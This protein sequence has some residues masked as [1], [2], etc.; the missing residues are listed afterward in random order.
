M[1]E[2]WF[3]LYG[4]MPFVQNA[5][6]KAWLEQNEKWAW[7]VQEP[8]L[9]ATDKYAPALIDAMADYIDDR[10]SEPELSSYVID[11]KEDAA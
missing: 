11:P 8:R 4:E 1:T 2:D 5:N 3:S 7:L 6:F 10:L 9:C